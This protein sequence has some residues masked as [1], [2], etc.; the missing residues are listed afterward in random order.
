[1]NNAVLA[2]DLAAWEER[3]DEVWAGRPQDSL[4]LALLD[5]KVQAR[6]TR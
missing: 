4:D 6:R 3:L 1:M 2:A 5:T